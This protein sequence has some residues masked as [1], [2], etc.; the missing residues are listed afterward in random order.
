ME[1][2]AK[3]GG[4]QTMPQ[5]SIG[6]GQNL[7]PRQPPST[8]GAISPTLKHWLPPDLSFWGYVWSLQYGKINTLLIDQETEYVRCGSYSVKKYE[9]EGSTELLS[10]PFL[11]TRTGKRGEPPKPGPPEDTSLGMTA[12]SALFPDLGGP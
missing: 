7:N 5:S 3:T 2:T 11:F 4:G 10:A 6:R 8:A 9:G 12:G 1:E